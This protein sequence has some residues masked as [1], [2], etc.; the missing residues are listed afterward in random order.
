MKLSLACFRLKGITKKPRMAIVP[1]A[2]V[3]VISRAEERTAQVT[4]A[5]GSE[6]R[7]GNV[8]PLRASIEPVGETPAEVVT[9]KA[10]VAG[11]NGGSYDFPRMTRPEGSFEIQDRQGKVI[12]S[13]KFKYG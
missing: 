2:R 6:I 3:P 1:A 7:I 4:I 9:L 8:F 5:P 13:G 10:T 12:D 11:A